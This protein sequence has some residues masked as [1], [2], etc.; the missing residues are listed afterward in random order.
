MLGSTKEAV[1]LC[2]LLRN[3]VLDIRILNVCGDFPYNLIEHGD[4]FHANAI[5]FE[6]LLCIFRLYYLIPFQNHPLVAGVDNRDL[7]EALSNISIKS[8]L[9]ERDS[10]DEVSEASAQSSTTQT[11]VQPSVLAS[12]P[13]RARTR[14]IYYMQRDFAQI[15]SSRTT[16]EWIQYACENLQVLDYICITGLMYKREELRKFQKDTVQ[17]VN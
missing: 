5:P 4:K 15:F 14:K 10:I 3:K 9:N 2:K 16:R 17:E 7:S 13:S 8:K 12:V 1:K 6:V 11:S